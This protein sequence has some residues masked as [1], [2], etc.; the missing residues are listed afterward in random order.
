MRKR[1]AYLNH[2]ED[3][4]RHWGELNLPQFELVGVGSENEI[5]HFLRIIENIIQAK[6]VS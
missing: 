5:E 4:Y 3:L 6:K 1:L 2:K